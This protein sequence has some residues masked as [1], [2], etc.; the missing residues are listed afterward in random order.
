[1]GRNR[2]PGGG[3]KPKPKAEGKREQFTTRITATTRALLDREASRTGRSVSKIAEDCIEALI[4]KKNDRERYRKTNRAFARLVLT[5]ADQIERRTGKTWQEDAFT[6]ESLRCGID[7]LIAHYGAHGAQ[8]VPA[9]IEERAKKLPSI[10]D[11]LRSAAG[12]GWFEA[13]CLTYNIEN[14]PDL[15]SWHSADSEVLDNIIVEAEIF[16]DLKKEQG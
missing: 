7:D 6:C 9:Q 12:L 15:L 3:R 1:M 10:G 5:F 2:A 16:R 11:T 13:Q 8:H 4:N 14:A